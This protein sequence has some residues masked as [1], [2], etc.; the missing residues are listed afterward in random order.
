MAMNEFRARHAA[1]LLGVQA[2]FLGTRRRL[3]DGQ[4]G[5]RV[6][7]ACGAWARRSAPRGPAGSRSR[8]R[9]SPAPVPARIRPSARAAS[10][11][12]LPWKGRGRETGRGDTRPRTDT[13]LHPM[14]TAQMTATKTFFRTIRGLPETR[15]K[16]AV[17]LHLGSG[18]AQF[19]PSPGGRVTHPSC[20]EAVS[21]FLRLCSGNGNIP[22][23]ASAGRRPERQPSDRFLPRPCKILILVNPRR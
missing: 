2:R 23:Y 1:R 16:P 11:R 18:L 4:I 5:N 19:Q 10:A 20:L 12:A 21:Q 22:H 17:T 6:G 3:L 7:S 13:P 8:D 14:R 15:K 9:R